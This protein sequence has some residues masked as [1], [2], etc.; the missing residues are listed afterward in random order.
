LVPDVEKRID[1][2][3]NRNP[4]V[5]FVGAVDNLLEIS[6]PPL[7]WPTIV[8]VCCTNQA[9]DTCLYI[10]ASPTHWVNANNQ[11]KKNGTH[12]RTTTQDRHYVQISV[13]V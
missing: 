11:Q 5:V 9:T 10:K 4:C 13:R 7:K 6:I 12:R 2:N 1:I 3:N 8:R